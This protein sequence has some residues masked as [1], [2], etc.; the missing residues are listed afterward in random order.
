MLLEISR[1][2]RLCMHFRNWILHF[3]KKVQFA[4]PYSTCKCGVHQEFRGRPSKNLEATGRNLEFLGERCPVLST[5][6][7]Y[8]RFFRDPA[9]EACLTTYSTSS[10]YP[11]V[12]G[13]VELT[14]RWRKYALRA[15]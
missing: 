14:L 7:I 4:V 2:K 8:I 10:C 1:R 13:V 3:V 11:Q 5:S 9:S 6:T 12:N 15:A